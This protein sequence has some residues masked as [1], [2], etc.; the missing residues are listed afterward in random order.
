MNIFRFH[1]FRVVFLVCGILAG[2]ALAVD[3]DLSFQ[4]RFQT[5]TYLGKEVNHLLTLPNGKIIA[6]GHFN[7]YN[8]QPVGALIRLKPDAT[9]DT[10]F[11]N[12]L[13]LPG[14]FNPNLGKVV[15]QPDGKLIVL[16]SAALS[17]GRNI[18]YIGR[19]TADGNLDTSFSANYIYTDLTDYDA[20]IDSSGRLVVIGRLYIV[21][22]GV[23]K[24]RNIV[25]LND[26]GTIDPSFN[27]A[28]DSPYSRKFA[29]QGNNVL[30]IRFDQDGIRSRLYRLN[31]DGSEDPSFVSPIVAGLVQDLMVQADGRI[32]VLEPYSLKRFNADGSTDANFQVQPDF[33]G[34]TSKLFLSNDG[35]ITVIYYP[36]GSMK[37]VRFLN[38][39][40]V[41]PTFTAHTAHDQNGPFLGQALLADD[42]MLLGDCSSGPPTNWFTKLLPNGLVD[43]AF[44]EGRPGF[45]NVIRSKIQSL[46]T[47]PDGRILAAGAF[48]S[49]NGVDQANIAMLHDDGSLDSSFKIA[50]AG[51]GD[52]FTAI[53]DLYHVVRD[54]NGKILV[55]GNFE[56]VLNGFQRAN[57]VRLNADGSIDPTFDIT[58]SIQ[59]LSS[60]GGGSNPLLERGDSR[61]LVG[62]SRTDLSATLPPALLNPDGSRAAGFV[63]TVFFERSHVAI[64]GI[65]L[66]P[67]GKIVLAGETRMAG[68]SGNSIDRGF[69][70][71][72]LPDGEYDT[73][74]P[75][76]ELADVVVTA[77]AVRP[78]GGIV[79]VNRSASGSS[80]IRLTS[81]GYVDPT[82]HFDGIADGRI[83][84]L[85][86]TE[87]GEVLIGG[88]FS[89]VSGQARRNLALLNNDGT[90]G[91]H[92]GSPND[93][94]LCIA[95]DTA[96]RILIGGRFTSISSGGQNVGAPYL[97]RLTVSAAPS[98]RAPFD[99]DG[100]GRS[101]VSVL[102]PSD[103]SWYLDRSS[104][105]FQGMHFGAAGD[106]PVP[107]D[108][109]GDGKTDIAVYRPATGVW[110]IVN[111]G[112]GSVTY[113]TFGLNEDVPTPADY[114]GD[115]RADIS[116]F[117]PST[118]I[119]YRLNSSDGGSVAVQFGQDGDR[120]TAGD[121]DGDGKADIGVWR[122]STGTWYHIRSINGSAF[123][124]TFGTATDKIVP[125]D[126][127]G[128]GKTDIA[129]YRPANG[130]WYI[131][132]SSNA[133]YTTTVFGLATDIPVPGDFDGDGKADIAVF[134]P[135]SGTWYV[136][137][138]SNGSFTAHA[139]GTDGDIPT[140]AAFSY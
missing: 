61:I 92:A 73:Y 17:D 72:L 120:P 52:H 115:G 2:Q 22:N 80:V 113:S 70:V 24:Q 58:P 128:D 68:P 90:L 122:P 140:L 85:S 5:S 1:I 47:F 54:S 124:E 60:V 38:D 45:Q 30:K 35:K 107:A 84:A 103:S 76:Y 48:D 117:R 43:E 98:T 93:E 108:Y 28:I 74:F 64:H 23:V 44:N 56:Y 20:K 132:S 63:P 40:S 78:G 134:R 88:L 26:D 21:E 101:D 94:V 6:R 8:G 62:T 109:D 83:N 106:K 33:S 119:W 51:P 36:P 53:H 57:I 41:D 59:D 91:I 133:T 66:Q 12:H 15:V 139:W 13:V 46:A 79:A 104:A 121:F 112:N 136:L 55:S 95:L 116:V 50:T 118:G 69:I 129:V 110:Y 135:L 67:D 96:E 127:D 37:V 87:H 42:G 49:V 89:N 7:N 25:R 14:D 11:N 3:I 4:P 105:G 131:R 19:L 77:V 31:E 125:A 81:N 99:Y 130:T 18:S 137:N 82:F 100:D 27:E 9:L 16:G 29:L 34:Y 126:H 32:L 114:D 111:S 138:S 97:A 75:P 39:G 71:R 102:R 123:G 65:A 86:F 10:T